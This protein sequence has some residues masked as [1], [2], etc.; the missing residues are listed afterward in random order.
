MKLGGAHAP[1]APPFPT[2]MSILTSLSTSNH[3][4]LFS[5]SVTTFE[6]VRNTLLPFSHTFSHSPH[7]PVFSPW[8]NLVRLSPTAENHK[9][10]AIQSHSSTSEYAN[11]KHMHYLSL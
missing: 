1:G 5:L 7:L 3:H 11:S 10:L 4:C 6:L 2:P 8:V 9:A